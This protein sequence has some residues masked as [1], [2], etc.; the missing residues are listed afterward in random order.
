M[1]QV[2]SLYRQVLATLPPDGRRFLWTYSWLLA[3]L[4]IFDAAALG[5]LALVLGP[6]ATST[7]VVLPLVGVLDTAG[8]VTAVLVICVILIAKSVF[9]LIITWWATRR[10]PRYEI[11]MGDRVLR[12]YLSAPW[13]DRLRKIRVRVA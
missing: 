12:A 9:A 3:S 1:K 8:V 13:R 10:M 4:A 6:V 11:A 5:L 7:P 2:V